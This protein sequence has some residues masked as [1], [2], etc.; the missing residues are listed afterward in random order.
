MPEWICRR[1][2]IQVS[3]RPSPWPSGI[4]RVNAAHFLVRFHPSSPF[5]EGWLPQILLS[6]LSA[7]KACVQGMGWGGGFRVM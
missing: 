7:E 6:F 4:W 1:L 5:C 3:A 2:V